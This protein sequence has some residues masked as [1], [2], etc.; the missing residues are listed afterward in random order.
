[1]LNIL[2]FLCTS[3]NKYV[4]RDRNRMTWW[5]GG[6]R[7]E[8]KS[9]SMLM[10][11]SSVIL[12][13]IFKYI[14]CNC[15]Y[16]YPSRNASRLVSQKKWGMTQRNE[17]SLGKACSIQGLAH[18]QHRYN[19]CYMFCLMW[20]RRQT[21]HFPLYHTVSLWECFLLYHAFHRMS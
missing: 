14:F 5:D 2:T 1:M 19:K 3:N 20:V 15:I 4:C 12:G 7:K 6:E 13:G 16:N 8:I 11:I 17:E 18:G 9:Q 21:K 10:F